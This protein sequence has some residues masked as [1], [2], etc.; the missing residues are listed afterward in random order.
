MKRGTFVRRAS[1]AL[2]AAAVAV[3]MPCMRAHA[4]GQVQPIVFSGD[5]APGG[6]SDFFE[7]STGLGAAINN[8]AQVGFASDFTDASGANGVFRATLSSLPVTPIERIVRTDESTPSGVGTFWNNSSASINDAGAVAFYA[9]LFPG[10]AGIF[11]G[12]GTTRTEVMRQGQFAPGGD[13]RLDFLDYLGTGLAL[14][15]SGQVAFAANLYE[16]DGG[17]ADN[18]A[19]YR[20]DGAA[21]PLVQIVRRGDNAPGVGQ[22]GATSTHVTQMNDA[23]QVAFTVSITG[24]VDGFDNGVFIG[25]GVTITEVARRDGAVP[26]GAPEAWANFSAPALNNAGQAAFHALYQNTSTGGVEGGIFRGNGTTITSIARAGQPL[27]DDSG[28]FAGFSER[29][30]VNDAGETAFV[31]T[32][33]PPPGGVVRT[34]LFRGDGTVGGLRIIAR[35][36]EPAPDGDGVISY[37]GLQGA[38]TSLAGPF[39]MNDAGQIVFTAPM[40]VGAPTGEYGLFF[41]DDDHGLVKI[42][43]DNDPF[44]GSTVID[45][46]FAGFR[47]EERSGLNDVGQVAFTFRLADNRVGLAVWSIPEPG[48]LAGL[49]VAATMTA[50]RR[51]RVMRAT[52]ASQC[53]PHG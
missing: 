39:A 4:Q 16:T 7:F 38:N 34:G 11:L 25:D 36:G 22:F 13:G 9:S 41:H 47:P 37:I 21:Q 27:P 19:I 24:G 28:S 10:G 53:R 52:T 2:T 31:C 6:G 32:I 33:A 12:N 48:A 51:R 29:V 14:N 18:E 46:G 15:S 35:E 44:L 49:I 17:N 45:F 20:W 43:R 1:F 50:L 3:A 23:G 8:A 26:G 30:A 40:D 42:I 5:P